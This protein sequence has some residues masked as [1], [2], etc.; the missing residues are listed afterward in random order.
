M[1]L[2]SESVRVVTVG[3]DELRELL[4]EVIREE[5]EAVLSEKR[6]AVPPLLDRN[7]LA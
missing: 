1:N 2:K 7:D 3:A 5:L 4:R 6:N